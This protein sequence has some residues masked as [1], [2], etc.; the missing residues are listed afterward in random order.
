MSWLSEILKQ[1]EELESPKSFWYWSAVAAISAVVKDNVWFNKQIYNLYP[2]IYVL[3]HASSGLKKGPPVSMA[4]Q[5]VRQVNNTRLI[6]GRSSIQGI[7]KELG[8]AYTAPGGKIISKSIAFIC[9]SEMSSSIVEDKVATT[10]L[11]DLYDRQYNEGDW[12][13]LLKMES[14]KLKDPTITILAATNEAMSEDFFTRKETMGGYFA[15]TFIIYESKRHATNSLMFK[16]SNPPDYKKS[17]EYLKEVAKLA[18]PFNASNEVREYLDTWYKD[19]KRT[20][21]DS[22]F[23]DK[24][25]TL[26]RFDDSVLKVAM[27]LS[28]SIAPEL[29]LK[30]EAVKEAIEQCEKLVGNVRKTTMGQGKSQWAQEKALIIHELI[31]RDNHTI[32]RQQLNK[33]YWMRGSAAE[34]DEIMESLHVAGIIELEMLG[35]QV[36][37][38]MYDKQVEEWTKHLEGK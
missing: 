15:R 37:Y 21:D 18:G 20:I 22:E 36:C 4:K 9:S 14:F 33:K 31:E 28:L 27:L 5:L 2:N 17:A 8:T 25:G 12:R 1:H 38:R 6:S 13:S 16:L 19:F 23:E 11:T 34:W 29:D 32:T 30:M 3:L 7:L 24:T 26:N 10:I 35:N